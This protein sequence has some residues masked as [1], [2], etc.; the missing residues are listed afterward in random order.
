M[1]STDYNIMSWN[2]IPFRAQR[3][4]VELSFWT[5]K[6]KF[7]VWKEGT[8]VEMLSELYGNVCAVLAF[9]KL[10]TL[11]KLIMLMEMCP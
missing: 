7:L 4:Y 2:V 3:F 6:H 1:F 11:L 5:I 9:G 8:A 10:T